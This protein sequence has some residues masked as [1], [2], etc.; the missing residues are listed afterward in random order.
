MQT[1]VMSCWACMMHACMH[2]ACALS[3]IGAS[4]YWS[5]LA[6]AQPHPTLV[7]I[8]ASHYQMLT[9]QNAN[10]N[11]PNM[12]LIPYL[13]EKFINYNENLGWGE[14]GSFI[15]SYVFWY[16]S[17]HEKLVKTSFYIHFM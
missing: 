17:K 15:H 16:Q 1:L 12:I 5:D 14:Q 9:T 8:T 4:K 11:M 7:K 10:G 2:G 13:S 6:C 3:E